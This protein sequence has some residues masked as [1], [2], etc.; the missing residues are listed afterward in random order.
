VLQQISPAERGVL[1]QTLLLASAKGT[2]KDLWAVAGPSLIRLDFPSEGTTKPEVFAL[3]PTLGPLRSVQPAEVNGRRVLLVGAR[4]GFFVVDREHPAEA[5][6]QAYA[7]PG[8]TSQL[9]FSSVVHLGADRGFCACHSE[10]G[11]VFWN[12]GETGQ[13]SRAIRV[14]DLPVPGAVPGFTCGSPRQTGPRNLRVLADGSVV[15]SVGSRVVVTGAD[16]A[17]RVAVPR[18]P[19][20]VVGIVGAGEGSLAVVH[21][22]GTVCAADCKSLD[23]ASAERRT[24]RVSAAAALPWLGGMRLLLASEEGPVYCVG[25]EDDLVTQYVSPHR[26]LRVVTASS[27]RVVGLSADRQRVIVWNVW[28]GRKPAAEVYLA[29]IARHRVADV[30]FA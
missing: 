8:V 21:E 17:A 27:E 19:A 24:G 11:V 26:D 9:G 1:L 10:A 7:D 2:R 5:S 23:N 14:T 3:P 22:D 18:S 4:S 15:Y 6:P 20:D 28:D 30:E 25:L 13:P 16:G 29:G 12:A